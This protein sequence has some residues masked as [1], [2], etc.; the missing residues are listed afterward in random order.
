[1]LLFYIIFGD[2]NPPYPTGSIIPSARRPGQRFHFL[3]CRGSSPSLLFVNRHGGTLR[4]AGWVSFH[5]NIFTRKVTEIA[6]I[7]IIIHI[8][9][10]PLPPRPCIWR[11]ASPSHTSP[12]SILDVHKSL[13]SRPRVTSPHTRVPMS[14]SPC[15][16]PSPSYFIHSPKEVIFTSLLIN[17]LVYLPHIGL[18]FKYSVY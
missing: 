12:R 16:R 18:H 2:R 3:H 13:V 8:L 4:R 5:Q 11:P 7:V 10:P 9:R 1:M 15:P 14:P 17:L 6:Y